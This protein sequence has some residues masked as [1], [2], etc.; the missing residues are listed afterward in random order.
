M[1]WCVQTSADLDA[2]ESQL[3]VR[4]L[5]MDIVQGVLGCPKLF[6]VALGFESQHVDLQVALLVAGIHGLVAVLHFLCTQVP[7]N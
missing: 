1:V 4:V 6:V 5:Q 7:T 2:V 3:G